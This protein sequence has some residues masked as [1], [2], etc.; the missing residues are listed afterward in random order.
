MKVFQKSF[1]QQETI[2]E[3]GIAAAV[4]V[5]RSGR[6]H[7]YNTLP[8]EKSE[9]DLLEL[10]FAEYQ[11]VPYCLACSSGGYAL[12]VAMRAVGVQSGDKVLCNAFTLAPVPGAI[13]N[14]GAVP[15]L[16]DV[17]DDYCI[18]LDDLESKAKESGAKVLMLSHMRGHLADMDR[19]MAICERYGLFLIEDCAHT[20]GASWNGKMSGTFGDVA[21][22]SAQTYKHINSG[23]GGFL[24]TRHA[25]VMARAIMHS[26]SYMLFDR[27]F[28][29]PPKEAFE[30]IRY[31][32]PNYSGRMDN[33]RAAILR[34]QIA[35]LDTQ[36]DRW[37]RRYRVIEKILNDS[38]VVKIPARSEAERFV[39]SSIQFSLPQ[40]TLEQILQTVEHCGERGV[41]LKWFG[42]AVPRDY[43]S[44]YDSWQ[45]I[46][47]MPQ[48]PK[49]ELILSTLL[50]MR[51]PLTFS[52][53]DCALIAEVIVDVV[54]ECQQ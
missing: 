37:N 28:A 8:G 4:E 2:P 26:G 36:C 21:C 10:E 48:L 27:H 53:D 16:V 50:D 43:T 35:D 38:P 14:S 51:I 30:K 41:V 29:A 40:F 22:F 23:E 9:T 32:T 25:D 46:E 49:T 47:E 11:G 45:Y 24:T 1:T 19:I 12:H 6:L 52:E 33:L 20:M 18:D 15:V 13:H 5:M 44:R 39:G 17:A 3:Q 54:G 31:D 7:R 42:D 34:P